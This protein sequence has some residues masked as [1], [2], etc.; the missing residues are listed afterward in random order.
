MIILYDYQSCIE[1]QKL[2]VKNLQSP[3][4]QVSL[5]NKSFDVTVSQYAIQDRPL[6]LS[7]SPHVLLQDDHFP[8]VAYSEGPEKTI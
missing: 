7:P 3:A 5:R 8:H 6:V 1:K 2:K 4:L